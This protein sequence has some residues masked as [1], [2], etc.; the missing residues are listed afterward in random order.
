VNLWL[1]SLACGLAA[2][3]I[4]SLFAANQLKCLSMNHLHIDLSSFGQA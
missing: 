4:F 2:L 1:N 3:G